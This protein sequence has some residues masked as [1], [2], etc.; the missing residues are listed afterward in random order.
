MTVIYAG[1]ERTHIHF[2]LLHYYDFIQID[3][4]KNEI[5]VDVK[6]D[7]RESTPVAS[8]SNKKG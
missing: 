1:V 3:L 5:L 8:H 2:T 4:P 7:S 6:K